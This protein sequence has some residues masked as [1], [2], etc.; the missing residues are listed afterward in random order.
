MI[1]QLQGISHKWKFHRELSIG[2]RQ[3]YDDIISR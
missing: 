3:S 2:T 1:P